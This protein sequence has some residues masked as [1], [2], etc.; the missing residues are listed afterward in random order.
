MS[1]I[2]ERLLAGVLFKFQSDAIRK[3]AQDGNCVFVG[4]CADY[5][6]RDMPNV[7]NVFIT[8]SMEVSASTRSWQ[9]HEDR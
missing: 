4:R 8:A 2:S 5:V 7:V 3:A 1:S 6:L 9:A